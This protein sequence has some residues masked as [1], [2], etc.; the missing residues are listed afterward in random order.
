MTWRNIWKIH[1]FNQRPWPK[2]PLP[3]TSLDSVY[4]I[5]SICM[6]ICC[7]QNKSSGIRFSQNFMRNWSPH[8]AKWNIVWTFSH[9]REGGEENKVSNGGFSLDSVSFQETSIKL[10]KKNYFECECELMFG[11]FIHCELRVAH[12]SDGDC[13]SQS[14]VEAMIDLQSGSRRK[15]LHIWTSLYV[16]FTQ[17]LSRRCFSSRLSMDLENFTIGLRLSWEMIASFSIYL[18]LTFKWTQKLY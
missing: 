12:T 15:L 5:T 13:F 17:E 6:L 16:L 8:N 1:S 14:F 11:T 18:A 7:S 9:E 2:S 3:H 4:L 10:N